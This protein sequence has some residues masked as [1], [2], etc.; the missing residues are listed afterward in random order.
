M[1]FFAAQPGALNESASGLLPHCMWQHTLSSHCPTIYLIHVSTIA[2]PNYA[3]LGQSPGTL[4]VAYPGST[5][6][7]LTVKTFYYGCELALPEGAVDTSTTCTVTVTGYK[8]G[9]S[10]PVVTQSFA[11]TAAQVVDLA[12]PMDMATLSSGFQNLHS[13]QIAVSSPMTTSLLMD[14]LTGMVFPQRSLYLKLRT[15]RSWPTSRQHPIMI[16]RISQA[17]RSTLFLIIA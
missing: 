7:T 16:W 1:N 4:T 2:R 14:D 15:H 9:K 10:R 8:A 13:I 5:V 6:K 3:L 11:F 12:Q 17:Q